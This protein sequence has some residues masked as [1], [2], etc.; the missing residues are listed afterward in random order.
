MKT[1]GAQ[2]WEGLERTDA[3]MVAVRRA[4]TNGV[5]PRQ[6]IR[7]L[8]V[9]ATDLASAYGVAGAVQKRGKNSES[10]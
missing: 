2:D 10:L 1:A 3:A 6:A 9:A 8:L 7:D 4:M 5:D